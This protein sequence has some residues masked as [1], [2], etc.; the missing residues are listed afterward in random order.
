MQLEGNMSLLRMMMSLSD[1]NLFKT[2]LRLWMTILLLEWVVFLIIVMEPN[3][4]LRNSLLLE[5]VDR[6]PTTTVRSVL[7]LNG[8]GIK[9]VGGIQESGITH[10]LEIMNSHVIFRN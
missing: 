1:M 5:T 2:L 10:M 4:K 8:S 6:L 7:F 3:T 9:L